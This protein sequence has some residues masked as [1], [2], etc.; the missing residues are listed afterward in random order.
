MKRCQIES[1]AI[2]GAI[3]SGY[4]LTTYLTLTQEH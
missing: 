4:I 3:F 2:W 1:L